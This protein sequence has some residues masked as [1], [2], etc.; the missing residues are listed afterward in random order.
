MLLSAVI[1]LNIS[2][3]NR[4]GGCF[5]Y[6]GALV[7]FVNGSRKKFLELEQYYQRMDRIEMARRRLFQ[8]FGRFSV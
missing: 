5:M 8:K 6:K 7:S 4:T 2:T 1:D 3:F